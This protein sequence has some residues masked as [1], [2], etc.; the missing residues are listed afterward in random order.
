M[1]DAKS[2]ITIITFP[3]LD[4]S[5]VITSA[6]NDGCKYRN[7]LNYSINRSDSWK[8]FRLGILYT[9]SLAS[10]VFGFSVFRILEHAEQAQPKY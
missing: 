7:S 5:E 8:N 2:E 10:Q 3:F 6:S 9:K 1:A 4:A